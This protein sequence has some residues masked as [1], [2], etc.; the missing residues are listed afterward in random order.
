MEFLAG[1]ADV[2]GGSSVPDWNGDIP[3]ALPPDNV[4]ALLRRVILVGKAALC[5]RAFP[6]GALAAAAS[7]CEQSFRTSR[8]HDFHRGAAGRL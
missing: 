3:A 4:A 1:Q 2:S 5:Q 7:T 6:S 8:L